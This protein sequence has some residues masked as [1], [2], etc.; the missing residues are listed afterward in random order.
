M[1]LNPA[2]CFGTTHRRQDIRP[3]RVSLGESSLEIAVH[4]RVDPFEVSLHILGKLLAHPPCPLLPT[5]RPPPRRARPT[6]GTHPSL[7]PPAGT[8]ALYTPRA[9]PSTYCQLADRAQ[10]ALCPTQMPPTYF[11][12]SSLL[13]LTVNLV[14][15]N[16]CSGAPSGSTVSPHFMIDITALVYCTILNGITLENS[17]GF[18]VLELN[19][20]LILHI[21]KSF[22]KAKCRRAYASN[23]KSYLQQGQYSTFAEDAIRPSLYRPF[24]IGYLYFDRGF[25]ERGYQFLQIFPTPNTEVENIV[26]CFSAIGAKKSFRCLATNV[27]CVAKT[28]RM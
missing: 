24:C 13:D 22:L 28:A 6:P 19:L 3:W 21:Q 2:D 11:P 14:S 4:A 8:S 12:A 10:F 1:W 9:A 15:N 23:P 16:G 7:H 27:G 20:I 25:I 18:S 17:M 26:I 5:A